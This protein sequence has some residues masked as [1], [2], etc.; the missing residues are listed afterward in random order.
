M[1]KKLQNGR[2]PKIKLI[3]KAEKNMNNKLQ[4]FRMPKIKLILKAEKI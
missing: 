4:N 1:N 2:V 3:V